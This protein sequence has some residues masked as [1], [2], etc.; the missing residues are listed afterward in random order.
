M[1]TNDRRLRRT[2]ILRRLLL[3]AAVGGCLF[4]IGL[5][6]SLHEED[7]PPLGCA[8][9]ESLSPA[10][11]AKAVVGQ[12]PIVVDLPFGWTG[13]LSINGQAVTTSIEPAQAILTFTPGSGNE[14]GRLTNGQNF[15]SVTYWPRANEEAK[16]TCNW[17]F[18]VV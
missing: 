5:A 17:S 6:F 16:Q 13:Q 1:D 3:S 14:I 12:T 10:V 9:V 8:G 11:N 2:T 4:G 18:F 15:A 7:R